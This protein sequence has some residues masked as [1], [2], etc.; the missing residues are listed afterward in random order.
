[1]YK[2]RDIP[3]II[4]ERPFILFTWSEYT[5]DVVVVNRFSHRLR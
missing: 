5:L 2:S 1:M 4:A 3:Q